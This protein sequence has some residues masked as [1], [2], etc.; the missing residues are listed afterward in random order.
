MR[1]EQLYSLEAEAYVLGAMIIEPEIIGKVIQ[2]VTEDDFYRAEHKIICM[3]LGQMFIEEKPIEGPSLLNELKTRGELEMAGGVEYLQQLFDSMVGSASWEYYTKIIKDKS[4]FRQLVKNVN[5]M[6]RILATPGEV[7]DQARQVQSLALGVKQDEEGVMSIAQAI[8]AY[9]SQ[10]EFRVVHPTGLRDIDRIIEGIGPG[11]FVVLA[12]RPSMGKTALAVQIAIG[13]SKNNISVV[14]FT[15]EMT[16]AELAGRALRA[17][18]EQGLVPLPLTL[19]QN[20]ETP[21]SQYAYSKVSKCDA[22]VVDYLQLMNNGKTSESRQQEITTIS[23]KLKRMAVSL[24]IPVIA[25]SQLNRQPDVREDHRPR[26]S[27]LRESGSL[28]Q[29]ADKV[30]LVYRED[31][32]RK[33]KDPGAEPDGCAEVI[34]AKNRNGRTGVAQLVFVDERVKFYDRSQI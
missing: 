4:Q 5:E 8:Q 33:K 18:E 34:I 20:A 11:Q 32:Y 7:G 24:N 15:L 17:E 21:D 19:H 2:C 26:I 16:C 27:D 6:K 23:R 14:L 31:Y 10:E 30:L 25:L 22:V 3:A 29:D 13:W 28:E 9:K 1:D 12:G